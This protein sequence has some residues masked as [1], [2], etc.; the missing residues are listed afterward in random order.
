[1]HK[2]CHLPVFTL[3]FVGSVWECP[4]GAFYIIVGDEFPHG[5]LFG[6]E[7]LGLK[8]AHLNKGN[9]QESELPRILSTTLC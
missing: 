4:I 8:K 5:D 1:V 9:K 6:Y 2:Y 3:D 7:V